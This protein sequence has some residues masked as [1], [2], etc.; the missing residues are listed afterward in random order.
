MTAENNIDELIKQFDVAV[1]EF[2]NG[3][4][5]PV[6]KVYSHR[7]DVT[8]ANSLGTVCDSQLFERP[9]PGVSALITAKRRF[10]AGR[11]LNPL[12][13]GA[14]LYQPWPKAALYGRRVV[15]GEQR[16]LY[17]MWDMADMEGSRA[18][19]DPG[20]WLDGACGWTSLKGLRTGGAACVN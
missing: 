8:L 11:R 1:G 3:N 6:K 15:F 13:R 17:G 9:L 19:G 4:P 10:D 20:V 16:R 2:L 5:E 18:S 12:C 7:Q 14:H